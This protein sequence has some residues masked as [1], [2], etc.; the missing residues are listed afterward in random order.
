MVTYGDDSS[1]DMFLST[2]RPRIMGTDRFSV[3]SGLIISFNCPDLDFAII[4]ISL[5]KTRVRIKSLFAQVSLIFDSAVL[6]INGKS[7][8]IQVLEQPV[9]IMAG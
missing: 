9:S 5:H 4:T 1:I 6:F 3:T 2:S 8:L 7:D